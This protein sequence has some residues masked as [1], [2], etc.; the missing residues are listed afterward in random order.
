MHYYFTCDSTTESGRTFAS[1]TVNLISSSTPVRV[2]RRKISQPDCGR[3]PFDRKSS[4]VRLAL[5][6][7]TENS[8]MQLVAM[9]LCRC[10]RDGQQLATWNGLG[11]VAGMRQ[12][13]LRKLT[14]FRALIFLY[15]ISKLRSMYDINIFLCFSL[16]SILSKN[17]I[18]EILIKEWNSLIDLIGGS[19]YLVLSEDIQHMWLFNN[20]LVSESRFSLSLSL[21]ECMLLEYMLDYSKFT[22]LTINTG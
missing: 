6:R 14:I 5:R 19:M 16:S 8:K 4:R 7:E 9:R 18:R 3:S 10:G 21:L 17:F 12:L 1:E 22:M 15:T 2:P 11:I 20:L 13:I